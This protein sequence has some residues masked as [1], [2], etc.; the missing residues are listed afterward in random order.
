MLYG[1]TEV[2]IVP[3]LKLGSISDA[4]KEIKNVCHSTPSRDYP[5][6]SVGLLF[7]LEHKPLLSDPP[8]HHELSHELSA[9]ITLI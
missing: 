7:S 3:T 8:L 6:H 2:D 9:I 1:G 5:Y 4:E